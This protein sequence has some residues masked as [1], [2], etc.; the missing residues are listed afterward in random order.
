MFDFDFKDA[1]LLFLE[2][3]WHL[4]KIGIVYVCLRFGLQFVRAAIAENHPHTHPQHK[5]Q[6]RLQGDQ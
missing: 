4:C 1:G 6:D 5:E 2:I 3:L